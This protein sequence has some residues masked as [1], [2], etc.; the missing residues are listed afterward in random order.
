MIEQ[1]FMEKLLD[2]VK[3]EWRILGEISEIYGGLTGKNKSDFEDGNAYYISYKNIF[4][5]IEINL[6]KLESVKV[7]ST[8]NQNEVRY[9]DV[10]FTG[11]SETANEVG[12]SSAVTSKIKEKIYLNSFSFG[13]RFNNDI[14]LLPEFSKYLFRSNFMRIEISKTASGVTRFNLSKA[15]FRKI[16]IPIPPS[17]RLGI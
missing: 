10:L 17:C 5:N 11:S 3:V 1:N 16:L 14:K 2:G 9:G 4:D 15:R 7:S 13:V 8:E 6:K 12:M